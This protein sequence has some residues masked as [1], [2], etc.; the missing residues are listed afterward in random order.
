MKVNTI[1]KIGDKTITTVLIVCEQ[2]CQI[3]SNIMVWD[4]FLY[5][6]ENRLPNALANYI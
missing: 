3:W 2:L 5:Q 6:K 1:R 4:T